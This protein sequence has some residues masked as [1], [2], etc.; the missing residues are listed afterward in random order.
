[1]YRSASSKKATARKVGLG[2]R[3]T[4]RASSTSSRETQ[5]CRIEASVK[6]T[7]LMITS[8]DRPGRGASRA[9]R[10]STSPSPESRL[11]RWMAEPVE[12]L[13]QLAE[14]SGQVADLGDQL[15][16]RPGDGVLQ[17]AQ[18]RRA[19]VGVQLDGLLEDGLRGTCARPRLAV[20][21]HRG[22]AAG[23]DLG[24]LIALLAGSSRPSRVGSGGC[25]A[26]GRWRRRAC[27]GRRRRGRAGRPCGGRLRDPPGPR[28]TTPAL[29]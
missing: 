25:A 22:Q 15:G 18:G 24:H 12:I 7:A 1:M 13:G 11:P 14:V 3:F 6:A 23:G 20:F 16:I 2:S 29:A 19:V 26:A 5:N 28:P 9:P 8:R 4:R 10:S 17:V 21:E 27:R